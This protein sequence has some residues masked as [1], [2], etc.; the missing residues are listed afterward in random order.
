MSADSSK[1]SLRHE[2]STAITWGPVAAIVVT[3][4]T[5]FA[6]QFLVGALFGFAFGLMDWS[7]TEINVWLDTTLAQFI[8][9]AASSIAS[10]LVL[11]LFLDMRKA[12]FRS[13]GLTR[14]PKGRDALYIV[15]GFTIYFGLLIIASVL[16]AGIGV[17]TQ[18]EQEIGFEAAKTT[19]DQLLLVLIS[20]VVL[21]PI[22]EEL[23][24]RGFL[25]G[26]LRT[27]VDFTKATLITSALFA[28]PHLLGSS[29]GLLWIA[30][31]DTFVLSLVL[32]YVREKTGALWASIGIHAVKNGLAFIYLFV[33]VQ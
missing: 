18:Q 23:L 31:V 15:V 2:H 6:S 33:A 11:K 25:F 22:V 29:T 30:A 8:L 1:P 10:L 27:K 14:L 26:G 13:L 17:D 3:I 12:G 5:Y 9:V 24:F 21:P 28:A 16:A 20:L 19:G 4:I 32:C 7:Q